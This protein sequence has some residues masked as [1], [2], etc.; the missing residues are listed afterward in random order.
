MQKLKMHSI[1]QIIANTKRLKE[2]FPECITESADENGK[3]IF[4][5]DFDRLRLELSGEITEDNCERYT[6]NWPGK[7][8][9]AFIAN[10]SV[11]KTLRPSLRSDDNVDFSKTQNLFIEGDNLDALKILQESYLGKIQLIYIDPPYNTGNDFVYNDTFKK[12][13]AEYLKESCQIDEI[14]NRLVS[15][16]TANGRFHSDWLSM[17][18]PRL[19]LAK[20]LLRNDGVILISIDDNEQHNLRKICDEIFGSTSFVGVFAWRARTAKADVPFGVSND[21]EWIVAYGMPDFIAGRSGKRKYFKS[22]DYDDRWRLQDLTKNTTKNERPNSYFTMINPKTGEEYPASENRTWSVTTDTFSDYYKQGKIVFPG[23]YDFLNIKRPAFRVFEA[24]DKEKALQK[25]GTTEVRMSIST[26]LPE[27]EVGRTEHGTKE[28]RELFDS[29]VFSYPKPST[30]IQYFIENCSQQDAIIMDFFA[31]S[32]TTAHAVLQQNA[33][34][35]GERRFILIQLPEPLSKE[36]AT[37]KAATEFCLAAGLPLNISEITKERIRRIGKQLLKKKYHPEWNKDVGFRVLKIDSSNMTDVYYAPDEFDQTKL[38]LFVDNI[39]PDRT[40]ED[41]LFQVM[42]DWGVDLALP[43]ARESIQGKEVFF[44]DSNALAACFDAHA[45]VDEAFIKE[46]ATY[47]PLRAVFRDAGFK[48]SAV[49]INVE[50]IFK[51]L[52]PTTEV[53][54]I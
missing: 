45:G 21:V 46:L 19:K 39:K 8:Q 9:A 41:L 23:D 47:K 33:K 30:L 12:N 6:L 38:D 16:T 14:G 49:K 18:Y 27:G 44:V 51:L 29:P 54:C 10:M 11:A 26:F 35:G 28:I 42:L 20:N 53:K 17:I 2:I 13:S 22:D 7:Q 32:G 5:V 15:N 31:G 50:Q 37:Q 52:S 4:A 1:N 43:I 48:D 34:D 36:S 25:Y 3:I 40:A 24:E